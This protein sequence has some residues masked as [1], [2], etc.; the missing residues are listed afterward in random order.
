MRPHRLKPVPLTA[1]SDR[2]LVLVMWKLDRELPFFFGFGRLIGIIW[3]AESEAC[4][5]TRR[6]A[7]MTNSA[8][9]WAGSNHGLRGEELLPVAANASIVI[10][11]I[12]N[13]RKISFCIPCRRNF[14]ASIA[15]KALVLIRRM[16][17][18]GVFGR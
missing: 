17:E 2:V 8:D 7:Y 5:L 16:K 1:F 12:S 3:L 4:I 11:K 14:V 15:G 13:V 18:S 10:G 9:G 6:G